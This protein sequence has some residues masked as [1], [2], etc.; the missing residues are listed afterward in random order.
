M[1][2][3]NHWGNCEK[4]VT[5]FRNA[6]R[7]T[8]SNYCQ[9]SFYFEDIKN[10]SIRIRFIGKNNCG[11]SRTHFLTYQNEWSNDK[12]LVESED[13][14]EL[15]EM[16]ERSLLEK[17]ED[18][19]K[20][21]FDLD[22]YCNLF[23]RV[24]SSFQH[25][26]ID[27]FK[28]Y[29]SYQVNESIYEELFKTFSLLNGNNEMNGTIVKYDI[30]KE[31]DD[32]Q[33]NS[34]LE[35]NRLVK[36]DIISFK[37]MD[38]KNKKKFYQLRTSNEYYVSCPSD[39]TNEKMVLEK[40]CLKNGNI[41][42][43]NLQFPS[44]DRRVA[45]F[46]D[47]TNLFLHLVNRQEYCSISFASDE[48]KTFAGRPN[49]II[50][51][52][53]ERYQG[54]WWLKCEEIENQL[55]CLILYEYNDESTIRSFPIVSH[56]S[57]LQSNNEVQTD[58]LNYPYPGDT[59][60]SKTTLRLCRIS[61]NLDDGEII[62]NNLSIE[63]FRMKSLDWFQHIHFQLTDDMETLELFSNSSSQQLIEYVKDVVVVDEKEYESNDD[64]PFFF[65]RTINRQQSIHLTFFCDVYGLFGISD[66]GN[67]PLQI[68]HI[69]SVKSS[70]LISTFL[71][72]FVEKEGNFINFIIN[73]ERKD[74]YGK[75]TKNLWNY[76]F[77]L[78]ERNDS[79]F[80]LCSA[81]K[82]RQ[83][84]VTTDNKK[85]KQSYWSYGELL[86]SKALYH[87]FSLPDE[88]PFWYDSSKHLIYFINNRRCPLHDEL[89][90]FNITTGNYY[91][92]TS[93]KYSHTITSMKLT[94][95]GAYFIDTFSNKVTSPFTLII[96][97]VFLNDN[98]TNWKF[99]IVG[100]PIGKKMYKMDFLHQPYRYF[101]DN[102]LT[103]DLSVVYLEKII[104]D[105]LNTNFD[106]TIFD[107]QKFFQEIYNL[108]KFKEKFGYSANL[109]MF[110]FLLNYT[111]R[112][113]LDRIDQ[114]P[115]NSLTMPKRFF[116][117][118]FSLNYFLNN[119][120]FNNREETTFSH[121]R[122]LINQ[123]SIMFGVTGNELKLILNENEKFFGNFEFFGEIFPPMITNKI[124]KKFPVLLYVYGGPCEQLVRDEYSKRINSSFL[125]IMNC[126]DVMVIK[127]DGRRS[128]RRG[129]SFEDVA[130][131][132]FGAHELEDQ[133][134]VLQWLNEKLNCLDLKRVAVYGH[135][136]GGYLSLLAMMK[137]PHLFIGACSGSP[138]TDWYLYDSAYTERYLGY[139]VDKD[140]YEKS[141]VLNEEMWRRA[142][143]Y[144][145]GFLPKLMITHG[146]KDDN[147]HFLHSMKLF[148][149]LNKVK[150]N[151]RTIPLVNERHSYN[152]QE[153]ISFV[154]AQMVSFFTQIFGLDEALQK[155]STMNPLRFNY[156]EEK[157][158][159]LV[160]QNKN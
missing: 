47:G 61:I 128:G 97:L 110:E 38:D 78:K 123:R 34:L 62:D 56:P 18:S 75:E 44:N 35:L 48:L 40:I 144:N 132:S 53:F 69:D 160:G 54:A 93:A 158:F 131:I 74:D 121:N 82:K 77:E 83:M 107:Y 58:F 142:K 41:S 88:K 100:D 57:S 116:T 124:D 11:E 140:I 25:F 99:V 106:L 87:S 114:L 71:F 149:L 86:D 155:L 37:V 2:L 92:L 147:V 49:S 67:Y 115:N 135:S 32:D 137:Y 6:Y 136:Y 96:K 72:D 65:L 94:D 143:K 63:H 141:N 26:L 129:K 148:Q 23:N 126:L 102:S 4:V 43:N 31:K 118:P 15:I 42:M 3:S 157:L 59:N 55:H 101:N 10:D 22:Y 90:L 79:S 109:H 52:E 30:R 139:P 12:D 130:N 120:F 1:A 73:E 104:S 46:D 111:T 150:Y 95:D 108:D 14:E 153:S 29:P 81:E 122:L 21:T 80:I 66:T 98:F 13:M 85:S 68:I 51:E 145:T 76:S 36:S 103:N 146:L 64:R 60:T 133:L 24:A 27:I 5:D 105:H 159:K 154:H 45:I 20:Y 9:S 16:Y 70:Y 19:F 7:L 151:Y 117:S 125:N 119:R 89:S 156:V 84:E 8:N 91:S 17:H 112:L 113:E 33:L 152:S 50:Q 127:F 28:F 138:V 134:R 39:E